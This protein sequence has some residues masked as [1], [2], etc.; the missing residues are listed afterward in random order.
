M[1]RN[2]SVNRVLAALLCVCTL[3]LP[4]SARAAAAP[5]S[6]DVFSAAAAARFL[7]DFRSGAITVASRPDLDLTDNDIFTGGDARVM[8]L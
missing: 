3:G 6:A 2:H 7:R 8:L 5:T 4:A 1:K